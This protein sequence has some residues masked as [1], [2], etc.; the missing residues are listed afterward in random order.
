[1]WDGCTQQWSSMKSL[2]TSPMMPDLCCSTCLGLLAMLTVMRTVSLTLLNMDS[3]VLTKCSNNYRRTRQ[4]LTKDNPKTAIVTK[5]MRWSAFMRNFYNLERPRMIWLH[6]C[7]FVY[8]LNSMRR[9]LMLRL[10][11]I[12]TLIHR[13]S[14]TIGVVRIVTIWQYKI[15]YKNSSFSG[16]KQWREC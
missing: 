7:K 15:P 10:W 3:T 1:M 13:S 14:Y 8:A 5:R 12:L 4:E 16:I 2:W 9:L 6:F 11:L